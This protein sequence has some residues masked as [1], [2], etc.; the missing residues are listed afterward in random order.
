MA[1]M[2]GEAR[3][4]QAK[5]GLLEKHEKILVALRECKRCGL[6]YFYWNDVGGFCPKCGTTL[7]QK[8]KER[9]WAVRARAVRLLHGKPRA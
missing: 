2:M 7:S 3:V 4:L 9:L 8:V 1:A 5:T 6:L